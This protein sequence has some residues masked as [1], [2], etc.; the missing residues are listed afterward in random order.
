MEQLAHPS[1]IVDLVNVLFGAFGVHVPDYLVFCALIVLFLAGIGLYDPWDF[2]AC[3]FAGRDTL[4]RLAE[5]APA[6]I[7]DDRPWIEF[8]APRSM[9]AGY[10]LEVLR[11][12]AAADEPLALSGDP[13]IVPH[14][15]LAEASRRLRAGAR[16][17]ADEVE[18]SGRYGEARS[19]YS[20]LMRGAQR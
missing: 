16:A 10:A 15:L 17:F 19:R 12:L 9:Y 8:T 2:L 1:P 13:E 18:A 7:T 14:E 3:R 20:A 5:R 6:L 11:I 4:A